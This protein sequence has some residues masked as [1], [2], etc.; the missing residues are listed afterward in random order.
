MDKADRLTRSLGE[1][2]HFTRVIFVGRHKHNQK[3]CNTNTGTHFVIPV[4]T[5]PN[6]N[7]AV[8]SEETVA[9]PQ[10]ILRPRLSTKGRSNQQR[11]FLRH[12]LSS[13]TLVCTVQ[14]TRSNADEGKKGQDSN[15]TSRICFNSQTPGWLYTVPQD[16]GA[17]PQFA[18]GLTRLASV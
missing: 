15:L 1:V 18:D 7:P 5:E 12:P 14:P 6:S 2:C 11:L 9:D 13:T 10:V 3:P 8:R 4:G 17:A 16:A